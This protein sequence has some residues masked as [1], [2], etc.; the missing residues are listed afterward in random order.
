MKESK[1]VGYFLCFAIFQVK[2]FVKIFCQFCTFQK[3]FYMRKA[4]CGM[5]KYDI[6]YL[7]GTMTVH[8]RPYINNYVSHCYVEYTCIT[9]DRID[10]ILSRTSTIVL[11][12]QI[13]NVN[14]IESKHV[15]YTHVMCIT[16]PTSLCVWSK[17]AIRSYVKAVPFPR[18]QR[19]S[20]MTLKLTLFTKQQNM[21]RLHLQR[22]NAE[23]RLPK[24]TSC[25]ANRNKNLCH[26]NSKLPHTEKNIIVPGPQK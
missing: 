21:L 24:I 16:T 12:Y 9:T 14:L 4:N 3:Y 20:K 2:F 10:V 8:T 7:S 5:R 1:V 13:S 17:M 22:A 15:Q 18:R 23:K 6:K 25:I 26:I 11:Q 19:Q